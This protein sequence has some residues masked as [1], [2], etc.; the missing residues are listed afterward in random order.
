MEAQML[1]VYFFSQQYERRKQVGWIAFLHS[2]IQGPGCHRLCHLHYI[3]C[4][5]I[6]ISVTLYPFQSDE[7]MHIG[8][9]CS[10]VLEVANNLLILHWPKLNHMPTSKEVGKCSQVCPGKKS[11]TCILVNSQQFFPDSTFLVMK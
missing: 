1:Q 2:V 10:L 3:Q 4:H 11:R 9:F 5:I 6:S 7:W 8:S